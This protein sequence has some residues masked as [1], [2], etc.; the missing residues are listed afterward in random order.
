MNRFVEN[1]K[2]I[3]ETIST[4]QEQAIDEKCTSVKYDL[5]HMD[6]FQMDSLCQISCYVFAT[7]ELERRG[8]T[9]H[10]QACTH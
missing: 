5:H 9:S 10:V 3:I 8:I 2:K 7:D 6:N 4:Q 1:E